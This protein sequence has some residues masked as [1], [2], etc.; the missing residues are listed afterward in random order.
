V[1]TVIVIAIIAAAAFFAGRWAYRFFK[2]GRPACH[3]AMQQCPYQRDCDQ[4]EEERGASSSC[5]P[6]VSSDRGARR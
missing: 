4:L 5:P 6:P 1:Q 3:C 2:G